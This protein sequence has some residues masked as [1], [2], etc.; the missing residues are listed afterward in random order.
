MARLWKIFDWSK[1]KQYLGKNKHGNLGKW[2]LSFLSGRLQCVLVNGKKSQPKPVL[3]GVPQGSVLRALL[4]LI[5]IGDIDKDIETSSLSSFAEDTRVGH[6][7]ASKEVMTQL[8]ADLE[9]VY[10]WAV[11]NNMEFNSDKF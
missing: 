4:F 5:L 8:Q 11:R 9:T 10:C 3:S 2:L 1:N 7:I 6:A